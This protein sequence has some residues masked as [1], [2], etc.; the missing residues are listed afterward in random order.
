MENL[1]NFYGVDVSKK[2]L[3]ITLIIEGKK[4]LFTKIDNADKEIKQFLKSVFKDGRT[5]ENTVFC[6]EYTGVY[7]YR[8]LMALLEF[9]VKIWLERALHIKRTMGLVRGKNDKVDA[10][11]IAMFAFKN[12]V[13]IKLWQPK[14]KV[15]IQLKSL[16]RVRS[17]TMKSIECYRLPIKESN[18]AGDKELA[19]LLKQNSSKIIKTLTTSK[20]EIEKQMLNIIKENENLS[21]LFKIITSIPYAGTICA[22]TMIVTTNEF[23]DFK[24]ARKFACY[25]GV[26]PFE[27]SSGTSIRGKTRVSQLANKE[28][29]TLLNMI[30]IGSISKPGEMKTYFERKVVEGKN[31]MLILNNIRNKFIKRIFACI[32]YNKLYNQELFVV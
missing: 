23:K 6:M 24:N 2:T 10:E 11:R 13:D 21:H 9:D 16:L 1:I 28:V 26:A 27:H 29:K 3:D 12:V 18:E 31:K 20:K 30:A 15:I 22:I 5:I 17:Q 14:R 8:L 25:G 4:V 7:N 32:N 19:K